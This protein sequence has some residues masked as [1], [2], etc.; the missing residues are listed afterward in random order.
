MLFFRQLV[1]LLPRAM[2]WS[3]TV[4]KT[5]RRFLEGLAQAPSDAR[6]ALDL[7]WLDIFPD[8]T[9]ELAKWEKQFGLIAPATDDDR[10]LQLAAVFSAQGGQSPRYLQDVVRAAGFDVYLYEWW[11]LPLSGA[12]V[13]H[14]PH[15]YTVVPSIGTVQCGEP[16]A[17]CTAVDAPPPEPLPSGVSLFDLYPECNRFLANEP[18]Y[19]VNL[20]LTREAPPPVPD[21]VTTYPYFLYWMGATFG[22]RANVPAARR[23]EFERLLLKLCPS[24][25]WLVTYVTYV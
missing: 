22:T 24:Q 8:T 3:V 2:A 12:P 16:L 4:D 10:R 19:L 1:H 11:G 13:A 9:R 21:D 14:D 20:N 7:I 5:L 15:D 17:Q 23:D 6:D 25:Q 18:G